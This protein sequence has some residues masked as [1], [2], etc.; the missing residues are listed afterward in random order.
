VDNEPNTL[1]SARRYYIKAHRLIPSLGYPHNQLAVLC[2]YQEDDLGALY[3][4]YRSLA[5]TTPFPTARYNSIPWHHFNEV[6]NAPV[7]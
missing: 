3:H 7:Q 1:D 6:T 2:N 4:Y 5:A